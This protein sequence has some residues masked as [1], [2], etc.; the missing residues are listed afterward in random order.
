MTQL[1]WRN[2]MRAI[3]LFAGV[4]ALSG[5]LMVSSVLLFLPVAFDVQGVGWRAAPLRSAV[6]L[7]G[8]YLLSPAT[9]PAAFRGTAPKWGFGTIILMSIAYGLLAVAV[10]WA[11]TRRRRNRESLV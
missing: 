11:W 8:G 3:L 6:V 1:P 4:T 7:V 10:R 2:T 5:A 9:W